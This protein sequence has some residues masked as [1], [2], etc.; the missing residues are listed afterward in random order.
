L[1][2]SHQGTGSPVCVCQQPTGYLSGSETYARWLG[3]V[4]AS[5]TP[6]HH[7]IDELRVLARGDLR[8]G[9]PRTTGPLTQYEM[10]V[11]K[12]WPASWNS[13]YYRERPRAWSQ[14]LA[15]T[16]EGLRHVREYARRCRV[17][18]KHCFGTYAYDFVIH[19]LVCATGYSL[20]SASHTPAWPAPAGALAS[21]VAAH[22]TG[23]SYGP[24][25]QGNRQAKY[26]Y[27]AV[28]RTGASWP[29][30]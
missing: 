5:S 28:M 2:P 23:A 13:I 14:S 9:Y 1:H 26:R 18:S 10:G 30:S 17:L 27:F 11:L 21:Q 8:S 7:D 20:E 6:F 25:S 19:E 16:D 3:S 22:F 4:L 29:E 12:Q 15:P 24:G